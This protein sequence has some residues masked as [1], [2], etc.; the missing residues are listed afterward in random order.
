MGQDRACST[1]SNIM[2]GEQTNSVTSQHVHDKRAPAHLALLCKLLVQQAVAA[3]EH[4]LAGLLARPRARRGRRAGAGR[5][6]LCR[7]C[8]GTRGQPFSMLRVSGG[9]A[10]CARLMMH[11]TIGTPDSCQTLCRPL[12]ASSLT[13]YDHGSGPAQS[14]AGPAPAMLLI[15][16]SCDKPQFAQCRDGRTAG[17]PEQAAS[18]QV[19]LS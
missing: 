19:T 12:P 18:L 1:R 9:A 7:R 3:A 16:A 6:C 17:G 14:H 8:A 11:T 10:T 2:L 5:A 15:L 4:H 13:G